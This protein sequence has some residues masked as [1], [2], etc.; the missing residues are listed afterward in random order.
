MQAVNGGGVVAPHVLILP[1]L[2]KVRRVERLESDE[3]TAEPRRHRALEKIGREHGIHGSGGLPQA[4]H[5]AHA[6]E[7][8][9]GEAAIAEQV[10]VEKIE[11]TARQ[12]L[13]LGQ[14]RIDGL[15]IKRAPAFEERLLVAEVAHV[16]ASA[17]DDD[18][19]GDEVELPLDQIA[20]NRRNAGQRPQRA[21][22]TRASR[23]RA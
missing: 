20:P 17:R 23:S 6:V 8:R 22:D 13:D 5:A 11:M 4:S 19:V 3:E 14:R 2:G 12:P 1:L 18:R 7:E 10:I 21:I 16:R 9:R 15:R